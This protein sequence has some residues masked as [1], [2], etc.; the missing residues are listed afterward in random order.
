MTSLLVVCAAGCTQ[1]LSARETRTQNYSSF[2]MSLYD[3][4]LQQ[5]QPAA[6]VAP[7]RVAIAQVGE[8]APPQAML[9]HLRTRPELFTRLRDSRRVR[10]GRLRESKRPAERQ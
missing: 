5:A 1:G 4:P 2:I 9:S 10:G 6:L 3:Q 7:M 8:L